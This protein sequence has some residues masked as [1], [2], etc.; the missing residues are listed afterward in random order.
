[1]NDL[2][3]GRRAGLVEKPA[4]SSSQ[5]TDR[6]FVLHA[7]P[8]RETSAIVEA[9]TPAH[10][11]IGLV[12]K[13]A[14]RPKSAIRGV[15]QLFQPLHL[16]WFGRSEMKT[17]KSAEHDRF[18]PQ[19]AGP[20]LVSAFYLNELVMKLTHREV[21]NEGL[22]EAYA[23]ALEAL[24]AI[25]LE[26]GRRGDVA[27]VLRRFEVALMR[28]LGYGLRL[29]QEADSHQPVSAAERYWYVAD[30]GAVRV[31]H[32]AMQQ[33]DVLELS[34]KTLVDMADDDYRDPQ[35]LAEAKFLMRHLIGRLLGDKVI[36]SRTLMREMK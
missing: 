29:E 6:A 2:A 1:M 14:K 32:T 25:S 12:A 35:T 33:G 18:L 27:A 28:E 31:A 30:R 7:W 10:G 21:P 4:K 36:F 26:R 5:V 13:G 15:L 34:G 16:Q 24:S 17:L 22:F 3:A 20:A 19:M 23:A 8:W 9:F 11:R